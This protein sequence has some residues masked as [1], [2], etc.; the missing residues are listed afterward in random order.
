VRLLDDNSKCKTLSELPFNDRVLNC[1]TRSID[2]KY[3]EGVRQVLY[4]KFQDQT[5]LDPVDIAK[6]PQLFVD[7]MKQIFGAGANSIERTVTE[8]MCHEFKI[9]VPGEPSFVKAVEIAKSKRLKEDLT[10]I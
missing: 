3:G 2:T 8:E 7:C 1:V 6:K 9:V 4:W 5:K 10:G